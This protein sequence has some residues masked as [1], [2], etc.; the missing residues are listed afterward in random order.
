MTTTT[1]DHDNRTDPLAAIIAVADTITIGHYNPG[2]LISAAVHAAAIR[3]T[4]GNDHLH[5]REQRISRRTH[6]LVF[7]P[8]APLRTLPNPDSQTGRALAVRRLAARIVAQRLLDTV[9]AD[10]RVHPLCGPLDLAG[11]LQDV[12]TAAHD[13]PIRRP[14]LKNA[15]R[16][17]RAIDHHA[18]NLRTGQLHRLLRIVA[19]YA[20]LP[21]DRVDRVDT[22]LV[23][24]A[25][26]PVLRTDRGPAG[27]GAALQTVLAV[28]TP[29]RTEEA[30]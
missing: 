13:E 12:V 28:H 17:R 5:T 29:F 8:T 30:P 26:D 15:L 22:N 3:N 14:D 10:H 27:L 25:L 23:T 21:A 16:L 24:Y 1:P 7:G 11:A 20:D 9:R 18:P 4:T 6:D 19:T 2:T